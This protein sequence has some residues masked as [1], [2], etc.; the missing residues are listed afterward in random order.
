MDVFIVNGEEGRVEGRRELDKMS[1]PVNILFQGLCQ[2][3]E[4]A[5]MTLTAHTSFHESEGEGRS[6]IIDLTTP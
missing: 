6:L 4:A 5:T 3:R 1:A 2:I